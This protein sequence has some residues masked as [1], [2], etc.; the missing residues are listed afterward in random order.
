M[1]NFL[2]GVAVG[3][4]AAAALQRKSESRRS[5]AAASAYGRVDE[6]S[7]AANNLPA[8]DGTFNVGDGTPSDR[9]TADAGAL[10]SA[11]GGAEAAPRR[12]PGQSASR[13]G[14]TGDAFNGS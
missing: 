3:L 12:R 8:D 14:Q 6:L 5:Y 10:P 2:L 1:F 9:S 7:A 13:T 4:A 11:V